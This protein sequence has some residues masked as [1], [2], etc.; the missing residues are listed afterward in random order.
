[1]CER[2]TD[3]CGDSSL[4]SASSPSVRP[5]VCP[6]VVLH[7]SCSLYNCDV[8]RCAAKA[9]YVAINDNKLTDRQMEKST[10][11]LSM[12]SLPL[13]LSVCPCICACVCC[14]ACVRAC[15]CSADR[16]S[17]NARQ[18]ATT[19][20]AAVASSSSSSSLRTSGRIIRLSGH[21]ITDPSLSK[22]PTN[23]RRSQKFVFFFCFCFCFFLFFFLGGGGY[24][25]VE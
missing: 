22:R 24:K 6:S 2:G 12:M 16:S 10:A 7:R 20:P 3:A 5:S 19:S 18:R 8:H 1:M 23:Q 25:S 14:R 4:Y 9:N 17:V 21:C 13:C 11:S 15:Y